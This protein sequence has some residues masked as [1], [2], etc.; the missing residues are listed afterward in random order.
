[1]QWS[2]PEAG[3]SSPSP[4]GGLFLTPPDGGS[5]QGADKPGRP[6]CL[7]GE[8]ARTGGPEC[9]NQGLPPP[10]D[11][12][13][14]GV[15]SLRLQTTSRRG[16]GPAGTV[17]PPR[18]SQRWKPS[19][20]IEHHQPFHVAVRHVQPLRQKTTP[21]SPTLPFGD[22]LFPLCNSKSRPRSPGP[23]SS[24]LPPAHSSRP[25]DVT[26]IC[27]PSPTEAATM[28]S[29]LDFAE[30]VSFLADMASLHDIRPCCCLRALSPLC[31]PLFPAASR[32]LPSLAPPPRMQAP[33]PQLLGAPHVLC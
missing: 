27:C 20:S 25:G 19:S 33:L 21:F 31:F 7:D 14:R 18:L 2:F 22:A 4:G 1:M 23:P 11:R 10:Q 26:S 32:P 8:A 17:V 13:R 12:T 29:S 15:A 24:L 28:L 16:R 9:W 30:C 6:V 5:L 3:G